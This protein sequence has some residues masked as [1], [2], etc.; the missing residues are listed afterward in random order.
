MSGLFCV[1]VVQ[2]VLVYGSEM[3]VIPLLIGR[4]I[5]VFRH[6]VVRSLIG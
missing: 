4:A 1:V 3:W 5:G 2:A 6:R